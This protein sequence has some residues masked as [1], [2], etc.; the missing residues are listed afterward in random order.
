M[1]FWGAG[2]GCEQHVDTTTLALPPTENTRNA[3][4]SIHMKQPTSGVLVFAGV[5]PRLQP[6][7]SVAWLV[8]SY[9]WLQD[10]ASERCGNPVPSLHL[11]P[12]LDS[13]TLL[14]QPLL[15]LV[16]YFSILRQ[17]TEHNDSS[18]WPSW[19]SS[20]IDSVLNEGGVMHTVCHVFCGGNHMSTST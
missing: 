19:P 14:C 3:G 10:G 20:M 5:F 4:E 15:D 11:L 8:D 12:H 6:M 2:A 16:D 7:L 18:M 17:Q 9:P 13:A 1:F